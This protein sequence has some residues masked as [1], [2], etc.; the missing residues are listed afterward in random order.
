MAYLRLGGLSIPIIYFAPV[1]G[2]LIICLFTNS[3]PSRPSVRPPRLLIS[4]LVLVPVAAVQYIIVGAM[5]HFNRPIFPPTGA[6]P[7]SASYVTIALIL[8]WIIVSIGIINGDGLGPR[9]SASRG[10]IATAG[11]YVTVLLPIIVAILYRY[12]FNSVEYILSSSNTIYV[13]GDKYTYR[14]N[15]TFGDIIN[16]VLLKP[17]MHVPTPGFSNGLLIW[18]GTLTIGML[19]LATVWGARSRWWDVASYRKMSA[20]ERFLLWCFALPGLLGALISGVALIAAVLVG[21]FIAL[22]LFAGIAGASGQIADDMAGITPAQRKAI[23]EVKRE[24]RKS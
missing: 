17:S 5:L 7:D 3:A 20:V 8:L 19:V 11:V 2:F 10:E 15:N 16:T 1:V 9:I 23:N 22:M 21:V 6:Y 12:W 14:T 4:F 13:Q 18:S 24:I